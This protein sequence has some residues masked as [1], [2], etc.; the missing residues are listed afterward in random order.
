MARHQN[1]LKHFACHPQYDGGLAVPLALLAA[2]LRQS[3]TSRSAVSNLRSRSMVRR[4]HV[5]G[6]MPVVIEH[7]RQQ[8]SSSCINIPGT[9]SYD[10]SRIFN[11]NTDN[12]IS[13]CWLLPDEAVFSMTSHATLAPSR[14]CQCQTIP[15]AAA[16]VGNEVFTM[17]AIR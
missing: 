11:K 2:S 10:I 5:T 9:H 15:S 1:M 14:Q 4:H 16:P 12:M 8:Y 6:W 3:N 13:F 17:T 7:L